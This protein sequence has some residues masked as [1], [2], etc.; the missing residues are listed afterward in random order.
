MSEIHPTIITLTAIDK[1]KNIRGPMREI[2]PT[3][4]TLTA[5]DKVKHIHNVTSVDSDSQLGC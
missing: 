2:H 4:I 5:I 3:I 1:M